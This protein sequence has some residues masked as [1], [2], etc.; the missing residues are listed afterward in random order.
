MCCF[1]SVAI[2][3]RLVKAALCCSW[4]LAAPQWVGFV[5]YTAICCTNRVSVWSIVE[6][7]C[8][9]VCQHWG[10]NSPVLGRKGSQMTL[11]HVPSH[12]RPFKA[13]EDVDFHFKVY[14]NLKMSFGVCP[15]HSATVEVS[16]TPRGWRVFQTSICSL[17]LFLSHWLRCGVKRFTVSSLSAN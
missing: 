2:F 10:R 6:V 16:Q 15:H 4:G 9:I 5:A 13:K 17:V 14:I 1:N 7:M 8:L 3:R 12:C 11:T